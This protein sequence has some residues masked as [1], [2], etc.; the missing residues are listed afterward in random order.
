M[1]TR[2]PECLSVGSLLNKHIVHVEHGII[3]LDLGCVKKG[4]FSSW[5]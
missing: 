1:I 4:L 3:S 5:I 2:Y